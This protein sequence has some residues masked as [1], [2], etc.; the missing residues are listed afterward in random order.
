METADF[1]VSLW[2]R[3]RLRAVLA[4][5]DGMTFFLGESP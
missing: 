5:S 4:V 3:C 2:L 1:P